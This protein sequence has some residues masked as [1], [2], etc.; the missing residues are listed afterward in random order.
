MHTAARYALGLLLVVAGTVV[1]YICQASG[2]QSQTLTL[3]YVVPVAVA[4]AYLGW[5]P[6][7]LAVVASVVAFDFLFTVPVYT[8]NV[9]SRSDIAAIVL[10]AVVAAIVS[11]VAAEARHRALDAQASA[12]RAEALRNLA[13]ATIHGEAD[14]TLFR[15]AAETLARIFKAPAVIYAE[16]NGV[17]SAVASA[18]G[19]RVSPSDREAAQWAI[20][21]E[22]PVQGDVYPFDQASFDMWPIET[23]AHRR[24]I[25][26]VSFAE[27]E[28]GR[29]DEPGK[30]FELVAGYLAAGLTRTTIA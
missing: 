19:A 5:G 22:T 2:I 1:A 11:T 24:L 16:D 30:L 25:L 27:S 26:G 9:A 4:A 14:A 10:L 29:P 6:A 28:Q 20:S 21:H 17:V 13:H 7:I 12:D 3:A 15:I 18:G 23:A 8:L